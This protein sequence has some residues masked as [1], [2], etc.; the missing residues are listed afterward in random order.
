APDPEPS[1]RASGRGC[2]L[3]FLNCGHDVFACDVT[4][5]LSTSTSKLLRLNVNNA[6]MITADKAGN[7]VAAA[8]IKAATYLQPGSFTVGT[9]PSGVTGAM[10]WASNCRVF[11]GT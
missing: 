11:N 4:D 1:R 6:D 10:V 2:L 7:F 8:S 5:T 3:Y 9:L